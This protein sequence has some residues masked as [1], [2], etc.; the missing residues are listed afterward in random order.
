MILMQRLNASK[1]FQLDLVIDLKLDQYRFRAVDAELISDF[2]LHLSEF[3][4][5]CLGDYG[6]IGLSM[7]Y[8]WLLS[9]QYFVSKQLN[10]VSHTHSIE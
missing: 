6:S 9:K 1:Y 2:R 5:V 4:N 7:F 3:G 8:L 10:I